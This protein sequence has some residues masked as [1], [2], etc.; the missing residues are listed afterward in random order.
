MTNAITLRQG[1]ID[2]YMS[3][4]N[5]IPLLS[6]EEEQELAIR[7]HD[8]GD[9]RAAERLVT[10]NLRFVVKVAHEFSRYGCKLSDLVQEGNVGLMLAVRKFNPHRGYR[11]I[12]YAV[13]WIRAMIQSYIMKTWSMVK[14]GTTQ[15]QRKLFFKL[16]KT[17]Q[18]L[19]AASEEPLA[20][21]ARIGALAE[22]LE[23]R[24]RDVFEMELRM[25][26]R[27]FSLE[28]PTLDEDGASTYK[29]LLEAGS[30]TPEDLVAAAESQSVAEDEIHL[31]LARLPERERIVIERHLLS[32]EPQSLA[33]LSK[34]LGVSRERVR[35]IEAQ[36]MKKV[37]AYLTGNSPAREVV[38]VS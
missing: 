8:E 30:P 5:R 25:G 27:D 9:L 34:Q 36:G 4:I 23:V 15:A 2:L 21:D 31:A 10:A 7:Y 26:A 35:Q 20:D 17:R 6:R 12:S 14:I 22:K 11:L 24:D 33:E 29:D 32:D 37:R 18:E 1:E 3:Q 28:A 13:W 16:N 38:E 19:E